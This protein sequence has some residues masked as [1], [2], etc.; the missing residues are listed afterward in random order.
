MI[1]GLVNRQISNDVRKVAGLGDI[2]II[3]ALF[4]STNFANKKSDLVIFITPHIAGAGSEINKQGLER[5]AN[6]RDRFLKSV[7]AGMEILD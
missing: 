4:K 6:L 5:A 2:P 1:S 7:D 3:G